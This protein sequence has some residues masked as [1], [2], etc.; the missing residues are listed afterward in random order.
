MLDFASSTP[1]SAVAGPVRTG[2]DALVV[3]VHG[4]RQDLLG[5][6]LPDDVVI[7]EIEYLA[8]LGQILEAQ[9][10]RLV[11]LL[12]DDVVAQV[13]ALVT[14]VDTWAGDQLLDLFL[15]LSAETAL[16][17]IPALSELRHQIA[18]PSVPMVLR[19]ADGLEWRHRPRCDDF[20]DHSVRDRFIRSHDEVAV[21]VLGDLLLGLPG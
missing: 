20:V 1:S 8:R 17:E 19:G 18:L 6:F 9:L 10:G 14:D 16:D 15:R 5:V 7:E 12:G 3:V 2:L 21:R 11:A 4:D 13:D